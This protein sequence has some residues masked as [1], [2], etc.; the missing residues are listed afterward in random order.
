MKIDE[1]YTFSYF[2]ISLIFFAFGAVIAYFNLLIGSI[3]VVIG[4]LFL[5]VRTGT[6]L[7]PANS[8]IGRYSS[9]FGKIK[10]NWTSISNFDK[11]QLEFEFISQKMNSRGTSSTVR[12]KTYTLNFVGGKRSK[13]FHEYS[14]YEISKQIL[15][16]IK[17]EFKLETIDRYKDIQ[18]DAFNRRRNRKN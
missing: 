3:V 15:D 7:D 12:T 4:V 16:L 5:F 17:Q 10:T 8:R 18:K 13:K 14:D 2:F 9:L 11:A 6:I 1:G